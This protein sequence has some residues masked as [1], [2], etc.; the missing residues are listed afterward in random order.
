VPGPCTTQGAFL[1][2]SRV[3]PVNRT[4]LHRD[5]EVEE[6]E[7]GHQEAP[8]GHEQAQAAEAAQG[9]TIP[10]PAQIAQQHRVASLHPYPR[11]SSRRLRAARAQG[12]PHVARAHVLRQCCSRLRVRPIGRL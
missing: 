9:G 5:T 8:Q 7:L 1:F 2:A 6:H 4:S 12:D 3:S 10:A 11:Q